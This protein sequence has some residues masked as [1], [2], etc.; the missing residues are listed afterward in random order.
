[1]ATT[2]LYVNGVKWF[3]LVVRVESIGGTLTGLIVDYETS[4]DNTN[5][6]TVY[7]EETD[8]ATG[9]STMHAYSQQNTVAAIGYYTFRCER[10]NGPYMRAR[11]TGVGVTGNNS[12]SAT[13]QRVA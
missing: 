11:I 10:I 8:P 9:A 4:T 3:N 1:V 5:W 13:A 12:V 7:F 6:S 2:A